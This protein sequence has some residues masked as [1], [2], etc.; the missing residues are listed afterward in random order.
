MNRVSSGEKKV[1]LL[2]SQ[3]IEAF[4]QSQ[5]KKYEVRKAKDLRQFRRVKSASSY[6]QEAMSPRQELVLKYINM[7]AFIQRPFWVIKENSPNFCEYL[8]QYF[9]NI[10]FV[11]IV[12][13]NLSI[14]VFDEFT[15]YP[16]DTL[17]IFANSFGIPGTYFSNLFFFS[18]SRTQTIS[19][20]F[21]KIILLFGNN[22]NPF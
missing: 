12:F 6:F 2:S 20:L 7:Q 5:I 10:D 3:E 17:L 11:K 8:W 18:I 1:L 21:P 4:K 13:G 15:L 9:H 22:F 16:I 19:I 14:S